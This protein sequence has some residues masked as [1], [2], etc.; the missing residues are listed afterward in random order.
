[1]KVLFDDNIA[2]DSLVCWG[3][4]VRLP[5]YALFGATRWERRKN[6]ENKILEILADLEL[7]FKNVTVRL[8]S[9]WVRYYVFEILADGKR[10]ALNVLSPN[11][12]IQDFRDIN[13][14]KIENIAKPLA[15]SQDYMLQEWV[16]GLPLSE[17][18]E[19]FSMKREDLAK[20]C[21]KL[22]AA[23]LYKIFKLGY[24]YSPWEDYEAVYSHGKIV[25]LDLTRFVRRDIEKE[26]FFSHYYGAPFSSPEILVE[27]ERNRIFWRGTSEK[28]Y[29]GTS[30]EEYE[31]LFLEGIA[32]VCDDFEEFLAVSRLEETRARALWDRKRY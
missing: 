14:P 12:P 16:E 30:R 29:F 4:T 24:I 3:V 23:L 18:R 9:A 22:T 6:W 11:S 17:F 20:E 15:I 5:K 32:S 31:K 13:F 21:I 19:G 25:L 10:F 1:M 27:N 8:A 26:S 7:G 2:D 28:D